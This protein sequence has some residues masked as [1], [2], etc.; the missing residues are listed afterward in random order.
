[1]SLKDRSITLSVSREEKAELEKI[2]LQFGQTWGERPN[3]SKLIKAIANGQLIVAY[4]DE[5]PAEI[6]SRIKDVQVRMAVGAI[7]DGFHQL[8]NLFLGN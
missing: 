4:S 1:M 8:E 3:V 5:T 6:A 7:R 2:A